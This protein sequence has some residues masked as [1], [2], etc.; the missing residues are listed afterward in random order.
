MTK[1]LPGKM[2]IAV[3][4]K[5]LKRNG[6]IYGGLGIWQLVPAAP[7]FFETATSALYHLGT[8]HTI[9]SLL[10]EEEDILPPA[11]DIA[12]LLDWTF[13]GLEGWRNLLPDLP[14]R[15]AEIERQF[16][17]IVRRTNGAS[18][19]NIARAVFMARH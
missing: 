17:K 4:G 8:G 2:L 19:E 10:G 13:D 6:L 1:W 14:A 7:P 18:D 12:D 5:P 16:P 11:T 15:L 9:C 3:A